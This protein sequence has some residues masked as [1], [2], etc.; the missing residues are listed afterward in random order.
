MG[1]QLSR[2]PGHEPTVTPEAP[3]PIAAREW[4][5]A[6]RPA[7]LRGMELLVVGSGAA[8]P[9]KPGTASSCYVVSHEGATLCLDMGQGS[10]AG[11]AGRLEPAGLAGVV[12]S[13]LHPDHFVDLV[14]LR[15][16]LR[17]EFD[18]PRRL[19]VIAPAGLAGRLDGVTGEEDFAGGSFEIEDRAEGQVRVGPFDIESRRVAHT[20]DSFG[21]RVTFAAAPD[22]PALVYSGDCGRVADLAPLI[23]PGDVL[24]SEVAFGP[25]PVP[26]QDLH[27]D[28][29]AV[30]RLAA[31]TRVSRVLL[32]H[33][34]MKRDPATTIAAVRAEYSGPVSLVIDGERVALSG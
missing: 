33:L 8:Y 24:L 5:H 31:E 32:T 16:Y 17:F 9:D 3:R 20:A 12:I 14:A 13:H 10:F 21:T 23:R 1:T 27:L 11:L 34:Q 25:G 29:A 6:A 30:G 19:R 22:G 4:R 26:V 28:G 18:P 15:H 2:A 7:S